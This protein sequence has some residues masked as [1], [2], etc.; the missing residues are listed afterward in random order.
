MV[1]TKRTRRRSKVSASRSVVTYIFSWGQNPHHLSGSGSNPRKIYILKECDCILRRF[2]SSEHPQHVW[3]SSTPVS[4]VHLKVAI[5]FLKDVSEV[6]FGSKNKV[7]HVR[8]YL[9]KITFRSPPFKSGRARRNCHSVVAN[10]PATSATGPR[11]SPPSM[12]QGRRGAGAGWPTGPD[13][14]GHGVQDRL[15]TP[16]GHS[17]PPRVFGGHVG[18]VG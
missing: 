9:V 2:S 16:Q 10:D 18:A 13:G 1:A 8:I 7:E 6:K 12:S 14:R 3:Q 11:P 5:Y 17:N 4:D 15:A